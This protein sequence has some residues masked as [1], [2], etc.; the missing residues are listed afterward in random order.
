MHQNPPPP[1]WGT[2]P[3]RQFNWNVV[4]Q[5]VGAVAAVAAVIITLVTSGVLKDENAGGNG[6]TPVR[7]GP[8]QTAPTNERPSPTV[9]QSTG[10]MTAGQQALRNLLPAAAYPN[11]WGSPKLEGAVVSA[12]LTCE[13][14]GLRD[15]PVAMQFASGSE[16]TNYMRRNFP[17]V[18]DDTRTSCENG[19]AYRGPWHIGNV[20]Q[21]T[22]IC[23]YA[24]GYHYMVW[25]YNDRSI[26]I[27]ARDRSHPVLWNWWSRP[28]VTKIG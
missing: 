23:A 20:L 8:G 18:T 7:V 26:V 28:G 24:G 25:S 13:V 10:T 19:R 1:P 2:P 17:D 15:F 3:P 27:S 16:A 12:A 9:T 4:W 22:A 14:Y 21:G 6:A 5:A 11:C